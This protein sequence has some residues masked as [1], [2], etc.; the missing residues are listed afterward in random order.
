MIDSILG[1]ILEKKLQDNIQCEIFQVILDETKD[2]Y[3]AEIVFELP[4]TTPDEM[5]SNIEKITAWIEQYKINN[6]TANNN[7]TTS[8]NNSVNNVEMQIS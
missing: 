8:N 5:E 3:S 1:D 6:S 4:S 7:K 2:S